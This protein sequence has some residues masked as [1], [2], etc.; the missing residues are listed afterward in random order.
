MI[1]I[2]HED[3]IRHLL[4][5]VAL[6]TQIRIPS[7]Q[8]FRIDGAMWGVARGASF[9]ECL[10]LKRKRSFLGGMALEAGFVLFQMTKTGGDSVSLVWVVAIGAGDL[11]LEDRVT[12]GETEFGLLVDMAI[13]A[14]LRRF[15]RIH[16]RFDRTARFN[17]QTA[18][19][20]TGFTA[21]PDSILPD[22][23]RPGMG[24]GVEGIRLVLVTG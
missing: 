1:A 14:C 3:L 8:H 24:S 22:T 4:L 13:E 21:T 7:F 11:T 23:V 16:D 10:M 19:A 18:T 6:Q 2:S 20:V 17:V 12:I 5:G 15:A 9:P